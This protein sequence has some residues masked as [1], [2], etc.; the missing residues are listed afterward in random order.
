MDISKTSVSKLSCSELRA[1]PRKVSY[2][3]S[4]GTVFEWYDFYIYGTLATVFAGLFFPPG[5]PVT[6]LLT[7]LLTFGV[8]FVVRPFGALVFGRIGDLVGR[9][10]AFPHHAHRHGNI[11]GVGRNF[12]NVRRDWMG[13]TDHPLFVACYPGSGLGWGVGRGSDLCRR[14]CAARKTRLQH[15]LDPDDR[16]LRVYSLP[17]R[18]S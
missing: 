2:A 12:A 1:Q 7:I 18:S 14:T 6:A 4:L 13:C 8:G 11:D 10:Y 16:H 5:N 17:W 3:S 15:E 9:K